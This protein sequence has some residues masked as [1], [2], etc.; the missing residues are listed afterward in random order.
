MDFPEILIRIIEE[1]KCPMYD[2]EDE[3]DL[4]GSALVLPPEKPV[5][6]ILVNDITEMFKDRSKMDAKGTF[7]C[8]GCSGRIRLAYKLDLSYTLP[9]PKK[10]DSELAAIAQRLR[11]FSI[12]KAME[13][14]EIKNIVS[15]LKLRK[16]NPDEI[17]IRRGDPGRQLFIVVSGK[18]AVV[19]EDGIQIDTIGSGEVFGEMSLI[20]GEPAGATIQVLETSRVLHISSRD[21]RKILMKHPSLQLYFARLLADRLAVTNTARVEEFSSGMIGKLSDMPPSELFQTLYNNQKTGVLVMD[22][23]RGAAQISFRE[24]QI[25][26][27]SYDKKEG[28]EAFFEALAAKKGRFR[29]RPFLSDEALKAPPLGDFMFLM[30]EGV[31]R[32]DESGDS[33]D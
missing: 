26:D 30:M 16:F 18:V 17:I 31:N 33:S 12:F 5:C 19:G 11:R 15:M 4:S 1:N 8:S 7:S 3:F 25:I 2:M 28:V 21:F 29:F 22:L 27:A 20:S 6:M 14:E 9:P 13:I 23:E 24:G 10:S 32:I